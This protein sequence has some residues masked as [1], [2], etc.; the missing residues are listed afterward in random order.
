MEGKGSGGVHSRSLSPPRNTTEEP[1]HPRVPSAVWSP[2]RLVLLIGS[3]RAF[4]L[5][6]KQ[7]ESSKNLDSK[8]LE[9]SV[10]RVLPL[11]EELG[12]GLLGPSSVPQSLRGG[13]RR[14]GQRH[15]ET[16]A[17]RENGHAVWF[18]GERQVQIL[19]LPLACCVTCGKLLA[20]S[21]PCLFQL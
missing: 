18:S 3:G 21:E 1:L 20:F 6:T 12:P 13:A 10:L 7:V 14:E 15:P 9:L 11:G 17:Q 4:H 2:F 19:T 16:G 5:S 8:N